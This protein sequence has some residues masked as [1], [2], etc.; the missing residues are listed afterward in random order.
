MFY[1][2]VVWNHKK[3]VPLQSFYKETKI[4]WGEYVF[5]SQS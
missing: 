4:V 1:L 5:I 2:Y 3:R